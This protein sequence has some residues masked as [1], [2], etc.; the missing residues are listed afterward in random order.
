MCDAHSAS[1]DDALLASWV[2]KSVNTLV[3]I[4]TQLLSDAHPLILRAVLVS[5]TSMQENSK[6]V[7]LVNCLLAVI[8]H[9]MKPFQKSVYVM[10]FYALAGL[11]KVMPLP[12]QHTCN[13]HTPRSVACLC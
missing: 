5:G 1:P 13:R 4:I 8:Y 3:V 7:W 11:T 12:V 9:V 10:H 2:G 6:K